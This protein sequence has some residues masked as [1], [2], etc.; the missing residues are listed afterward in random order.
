MF[1][2]KNILSLL[3]V[4]ATVKLPVDDK[5]LEKTIQKYNS[6]WREALT[7]LWVAY[8]IIIT[9]KVV[10][11]SLAGIT[12]QPTILE[13]VTKTTANW[14][15]TVLKPFYSE[16]IAY[17]GGQMA[18][19]ISKTI[20]SLFKF[21]I[22]NP[23]VVRYINTETLKLAVDMESQVVISLQETLR[24][25]IRNN[26]NQ[27]ITKDFLRQGMTITDRDWKFLEK[28]YIRNLESET[29]RGITELG[30]SRRAAEKR[31]IRF[32]I[33]QNKIL[34]RRKQNQRIARIS[35]TETTRMKHFSDIESLSQAEI[36]GRI[37][38][39]TKTWIRGN[40]TDNWNSSIINS[41]KTIG[42]NDLFLRGS[43]TTASSLAYPSEINEYCYLEYKINYVKNRLAA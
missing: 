7:A 30:L 32:A 40:F 8:G 25:S 28:R 13:S 21:D 12:L 11:E 41:G 9:D 24:N 33:K 16:I 19:T 17:S 27:T 18:G 2:V 42:V 39:A 38:R 1:D 29:L 43:P 37:K 4:K 26:W 31:A 36:T 35:R 3:E 22:T 14:R 15:K 10:R 23:E 20:N 5:Q 6:D 34:F